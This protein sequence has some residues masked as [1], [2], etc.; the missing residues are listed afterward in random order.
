[1]SN[2]LR[3]IFI[4]MEYSDS[5]VNQLVKLGLRR[6][7]DVYIFY[8]VAEITPEKREIIDMLEL[9]GNEVILAPNYDFKDDK[10]YAEFGHHY[11]GNELVYR[12]IIS[13]VE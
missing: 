10:M 13:K 3:K 12:T 11:E 1:M 5:E 6:G 8:G 4:S 9:T 2:D 7:N